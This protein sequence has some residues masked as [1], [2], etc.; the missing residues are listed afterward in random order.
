M[1]HAMSS[2]QNF[3]AARKKALTRIFSIR[4]VV[5]MKGGNTTMATKKKAAA[6][7]TTKKKTTKKK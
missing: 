5:E 3:F 7:K 4:T 1:K 2:L 6:K